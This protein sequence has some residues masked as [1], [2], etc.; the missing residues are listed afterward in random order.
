MKIR[1]YFI[2]LPGEREHCTQEASLAFQE[3]PLF[4]EEL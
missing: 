2:V 1:I 4:N 3:I